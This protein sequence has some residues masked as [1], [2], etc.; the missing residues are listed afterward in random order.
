MLKKII[1]AIGLCAVLSF[2]A[3]IFGYFLYHPQA[4]EPAERVN[5]N[6]QQ[7]PLVTESTIIEYIYIYGDGITETAFSPIPPYLIGLDENE[8]KNSMK[9][10]EVTE[11]S[12]EK[13]T[14]KKTLEGSS[15][16]H[17]IL[18]EKD[19]Y[20]AVFYKKGM[21][22][23]EMTNTPI[24]ALTESEKELLGIEITGKDKLARLL[25]DLET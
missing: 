12:P 7:A 11:F 17:Y 8:V 15:R 2:S 25:E 3:M 16:Q 6:A 20:L 1:T 4:T 23:K 19:G 14:V 22:L 9:G 13:L 24:N 5:I 10:F 18:A 21:G